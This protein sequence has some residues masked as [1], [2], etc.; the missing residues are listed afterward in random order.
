MTKLTEATTE[1]STQLF[2]LHEAANAEHPTIP[3]VNVNQ[4]SFDSQTIQSTF[5][6]PLVITADHILTPIIIQT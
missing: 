1:N 4:F 2:T 5:I 6:A 3:S